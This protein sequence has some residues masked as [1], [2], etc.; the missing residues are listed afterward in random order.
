MAT[1]DLWLSDESQRI[2]ERL[3]AKTE[4]ADA[5][6]VVGNALCLYDGLIERVESGKPLFEQNEQGEYV[7]WLPFKKH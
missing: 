6:E 2:F 4:A 7:P 5:G 1:L 3:K